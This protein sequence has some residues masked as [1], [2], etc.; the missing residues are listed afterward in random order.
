MNE[1]E[2]VLAIARLMSAMSAFRDLRGNGSQ[3]A[4][5]FLHHPFICQKYMN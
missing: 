1:A 2:C 4:S 5:T 3:L